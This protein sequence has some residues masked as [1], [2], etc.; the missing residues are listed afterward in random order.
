MVNVD[1]QLLSLT[2]NQLLHFLKYILKWKKVGLLAA[3]FV[4]GQNAFQI[5]MAKKQTNK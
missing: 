5:K 2:V 4:L 3:Q 1:G